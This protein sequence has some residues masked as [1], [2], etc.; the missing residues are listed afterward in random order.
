MTAGEPRATVLYDRDCGFCRWAL[1]K[2]LAWDR[3]R[4]RPVEIQGE[5]GQRLLAPLPEAERLASWHLVAADG[6]LRS[7]G[8]AAAPLAEL[9]PGGRPLA[10]AF[11]RF[12]R[13]TERAY[14]WVAAHRDLLARLLRIDATCAIR[15]P[16]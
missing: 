2:V 12:P 15:P 7:A 16:H 9:L 1:D 3:G 11:R 14:R 10:A 4:L 6:E 13:T 8:A 5:E